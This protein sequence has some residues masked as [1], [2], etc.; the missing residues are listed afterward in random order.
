MALAKED[1]IFMHPLPA[2]RNVEV[3]DAVMDGPNSV[4]FDEAENKMH[5]ARP[6]WHLQWRKV[7]D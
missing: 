6:S 5:I 7:V 2:D 1:A 4:I 3:T